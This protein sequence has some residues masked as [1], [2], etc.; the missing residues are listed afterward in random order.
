M[1]GAQG[2]RVAW[3]D[4]FAWRVAAGLRRAGGC[5]AWGCRRPVPRGWVSCL[6]S[7]LTCAARVAALLGFA[8]RLR[9][10]GGPLLP[11][12]FSS[13]K[14]G[15][16]RSQY[17]QESPNVSFCRYN[18]GQ[19]PIRPALQHQPLFKDLYAWRVISSSAAS[20]IPINISKLQI[21]R[22]EDIAS[23]SP[24]QSLYR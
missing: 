22:Y 14:Y 4:R 16:N 17:L 7:S 19:A 12:A 2:S 15:L 8:A 1:R 5:L 23:S 3:G 6:G 24:P 10:T 9:R 11:N 20:H 21:H 18:A 13:S